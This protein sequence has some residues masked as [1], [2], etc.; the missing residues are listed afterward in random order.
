MVGTNDIGRSMD[1]TISQAFVTRLHNACHTLGIPTLNVAPPHIAAEG[2][3]QELR[4]KM[5]G[6]RRRLAE[7]MS[8]WASG[9]P[10]VLLSLDCETLVPKSVQQ[11]WET[12]EI[13][14]S[15]E[16]SKQLGM[17]LA[18]KLISALGQLTPREELDDKS[19]ASSLTTQKPV[20]TPRT[21]L[22]Q[23]Q[24]VVRASNTLNVGGGTP[25][26]GIINN[27]KQPMAMAS[28]MGMY[29][30]CRPSLVGAPMARMVAVR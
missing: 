6:L 25:V 19:C 10:Q 20:A 7:T 22:R 18:S 4:T 15:I 16:G 11:L 2:G 9:C 29:R 5:R 17:Q 30:N 8:K 26:V 21:S 12:D 1:M 28:P 13:H 23:L 24:P 3:R 14:L 27:L